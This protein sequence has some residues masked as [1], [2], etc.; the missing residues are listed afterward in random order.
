M[1]CC[2]AVAHV[3]EKALN[4]LHSWVPPIVHRDMK[5]LNLLVDSNWTVKV[6]DFGLSRFTSGAASNLSTLGKVIAW[7]AS[8]LVSPGLVAAAWNVCLQ[9]SRGVFWRS[10]HHQG[11]LLQ[12]GSD[13]LGTGHARS[14]GRI[15]DALFRVS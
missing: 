3:V 12:R 5:S 1:P 7:C 8:V 11:R 2:S 15:L 4:T 14:D 13:L 9:R 10:V 6:S